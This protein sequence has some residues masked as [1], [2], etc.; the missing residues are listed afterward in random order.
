MA[1]R[2]ITRRTIMRRLKLGGLALTGLALVIGGMA[3]FIP[4]ANALPTNAVTFTVTPSFTSPATVGSTANP[5]SLTITNA[6]GGTSSTGTVTI[7]TIHFTPTCDTS[8]GIATCPSGSRETGDLTLS[9]TGTGEAGTAC[10]GVT[11]TN[12]VDLAAAGRYSITPATPVTL[13][14]PG[15]PSPTC[16]IDFTYNVVSAPT[17]DAD[18]STPGL[19]TLQ[20]AEINGTNV[21]GSGFTGISEGVGETT[22]GLASPTVATTASGTVVIGNPISDNADLTGGV[23]PTGTMSFALYGPS[24]TA[25]CAPADLVGT[26]LVPDTV[27]GNGTYGS[28]NYTTTAAGTY[29]WVDSY[30]GDGNNNSVTGGCSDANE[31]VVV[32]QASPTV[33]TTASATVQVGN[34]I[35]DSAVIA[36]GYNPT[37]TLTFALYGPSPTPSCVPGD[38]V[39]TGL[40]PDTVSGNGTYGSGSYLAT[41]AGTYYWVDSYTGDGNNNSVT[42]GCGDANES[43]V[44]AKNSPTVATTA[45]ASVVVGN[46]I[47]DS[48]VLSGGYNPTGTLTFSLYGPSATPVCNNTDLVATGLTPDTVSGNGTYGSGNYTTTLAGTYYWNVAYS[49][50]PNNNGFSGGC[51]DTAESVVI[52]KAAPLLT[53]QS[54]PNTLIGSNVTDVATLT[55]GYQPTGTV[56]FSLYGPSPTVSCSTLVQT[57]TAPVTFSGGAYTATSPGIAP[58][59]VGTYY[60]TASYGG[61]VNNNP[62]AQLCGG[63]NESVVVS[64][65]ISP[66]GSSLTAEG[67]VVYSQTFSVGSS[68]YT[69]TIG[70]PGI[71][72]LSMNPT[73]GV[74]SGTPTAAGHYSL[75]VTA[76]QTGQ[77]TFTRTYAFAVG[78]CIDGGNP[79]LPGG[80]HG[81]AY[82]FTLTGSAGTGPYRFA[83]NG[84]G[85]PPGLSLAPSGLVSGTPTTPGTYTFTVQVLDSATSVNI[86]NMVMTLTIT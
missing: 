81:H 60:W 52:T 1:A 48:G 67:C 83:L 59:S 14:A 75:M 41:T 39:T 35:S 15:G 58:T 54:S 70:T 12:T 8:P 47:S 31:S 32:S 17:T 68:G 10:A 86:G 43:V 72:G 73:T 38:L 63:T 18:S 62:A 37:G 23:T 24:A 22:I 71:P 11:F 55:G 16:V 56:T 57:V 53:T 61:D 6:S 29:Y 45:S 50:D 5:A 28:G 51:L 36:N 21:G 85:L 2:T 19:Q 27:T 33:V 40:T 9:A 26:G 7:N 77:P 74:L 44:V 82:S 30:S 20:L 42:G 34:D 79:T 3:S 25:V 80:T 13:S 4:E 64:P 65:T 76:K 66:T 84:G 78:P 46:T 69:W 49:G